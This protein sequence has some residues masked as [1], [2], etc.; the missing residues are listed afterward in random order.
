MKNKNLHILW[1]LVMSLQG[2]LILSKCK[3]LFSCWTSLS[4]LKP[5]WSGILASCEVMAHTWHLERRCMNA[6]LLDKW[7]DFTKLE[8]VLCASLAGVVERVNKLISVTPV[9]TRFFVKLFEIIILT[10]NVQGTMVKL[11]M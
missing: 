3:P 7:N 2:N 11:A 9:K 1:L 8:Q 5:N 10:S 4:T 6:Q